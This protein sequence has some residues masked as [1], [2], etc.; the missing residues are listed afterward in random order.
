MISVT[1]LTRNSQ[2]YLREVLQSLSSFDEVAILDTGSCDN[3]L[4]IASQ[5][6]NVVIYHSS[7]DGF[8]KAH[9]EISSLAKHDW[10]L[11]IDSDEIVTREL[12]KEIS[13][14]KLSEDRVYSI[15]RNNYYRGVHIKWC[16]WYPDRQIR[17]YNKTKTQ[18][19][20]AEVHEAIISEGMKIISLKNPLKHFPYEKTS[21]F[22]SKMQT[23]SSLFAKQY[24]GKKKSSVRHAICH[25][26]FAFF[27]SYILKR[28]L[29]GGQEGFIISLYNANTA[30]Y[31]Y[32]KLY[33]KNQSLENK[34][35]V[36]Q[37]LQFEKSEDSP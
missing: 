3:T 36:P 32:L 35:Q 1:I 17:L 5:F 14:L 20:Q 30:F 29:L 10:I 37:S 13:S 6:P 25:G 22:L 7:F 27:K 31:K 34:R 24:A 4:K 33:E 15:P 21:D 26:L 11:S 2:K 18:F 9:N 16:G 23:Y 12:Y 28:G 8:G 19:S